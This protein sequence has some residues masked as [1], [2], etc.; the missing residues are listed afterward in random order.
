MI[1]FLVILGTG[2]LIAC[3]DDVAQGFIL[4]RD[5]LFID[6]CWSNISWFLVITINFDLNQ[7]LAA[8]IL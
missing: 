1:F 2:I 5:V 3:L 7:F 4:G 6:F 8:M